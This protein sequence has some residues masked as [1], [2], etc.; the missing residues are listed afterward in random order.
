LA[1]A[2]LAVYDCRL[3]RCKLETEADALR[4]RH[5]RLPLAIPRGRPIAVPHP[6]RGETRA[7]DARPGAI[8]P[9]LVQEALAV[10][11]GQCDVGEIHIVGAPRGP[12]VRGS[13]PFALTEENQL[14]TEAFA[15]RR[16]YVAGV[17]PPLGAEVGMFEMIARELVAIAGQSIT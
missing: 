3:E 4:H 2:L 1:H 10:D 17:V 8:Q 15:L 6:L 16:A 5:T 12:I 11:I 13:A 14:E 9:L 7:R